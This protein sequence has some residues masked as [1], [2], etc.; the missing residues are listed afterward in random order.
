MQ[1]ACLGLGKKKSYLRRSLVHSQNQWG[2]NLYG[3]MHEV[4]VRHNNKDVRVTWLIS[5]MVINNLTL[6]FPSLTP[7]S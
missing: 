6:S 7:I 3:M 1:G 2:Q 5:F 4:N